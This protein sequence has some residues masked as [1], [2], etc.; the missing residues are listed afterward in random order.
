MGDMDIADYMCR[1]L[2]SDEPMISPTRFHNS[3]HNAPR[4]TGRSA[5]A[6]TLPTNAVSAFIHSVPVSLV[7]AAIQCDT[8]EVPVLWVTVDMASP[9]ALKDVIVIDSPCAFALMLLPEPGP[10]TTTF[11]LDVVEGSG[12]WPELGCRGL[13]ELYSSQPVGAPVAGARTDGLAPLRAVAFAAQ[14][15]LRPAADGAMNR[16]VA[17]HDVVIV[18]GGLA[19]LT[20][21]LQLRRRYPDLDVAVLERSTH[22]VPLTVHKVGESTVEIGSHYLASVAGLRDHLDS[23]QLRKFGLRFFFGLGTGSIE[24][25]DELGVSHV[26]STPTW[27]VDRGVLE[28]ELAVRARAAGVTFLDGSAARRIEMNG[29]KRVYY[30][31]GGERRALESRWLID[32]ASR[33]SPLRHRLRLHRATIMRSTRIGSGS[34]AR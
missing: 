26:F 29:V 11:G 17:S 3:V 1:T 33:A 7:E 5:R 14:R 31:S 32:A 18:G 24:Q 16:P 9:G 22:P 20:L 21:A 27:Q 19:G 8:E 15:R 12:R 4:A 2:A 23:R 28:N 10:A 34:R 13:R 30:E 25:A 6:A